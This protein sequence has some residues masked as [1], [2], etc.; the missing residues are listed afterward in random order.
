VAIPCQ[1]CD[2]PVHE[3]VVICPHCGGTTGVPDDPLALAEIEILDELERKTPTVPLP[4][5]L[6][7]NILAVP[8]TPATPELPRAVAHIR[9]R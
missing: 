8:D 3:H 2:Q 4:L 7:S 1:Q 9:R 5:L 6:T